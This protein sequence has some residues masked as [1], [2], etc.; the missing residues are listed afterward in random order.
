MKYANLAAACVALFFC[1]MFAGCTSPT[2]AEIKPIDT[3][4]TA[5][6]VPETLVTVVETTTTLESIVPLPANLY[7]D[8]RLTKDRPTSK[9]HM[10]YNGGNGEIFVQ[11]VRLKV[12]RS[13]GTVTD[14]LLDGGN[15]PKRGD[16][17]VVV[18]TRTGDHCEV[19]VTTAGK[20]YK[21]IDEDLY[22][23]Q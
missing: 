11:S 9:I 10:L 6:V 7:V 1:A 5:T 4:V 12:T 15:Q 14:Q 13:D 20:V 18:G 22:P 21:I 23:I 8:V 19:W 16:E 2:Q 17:M 3:T